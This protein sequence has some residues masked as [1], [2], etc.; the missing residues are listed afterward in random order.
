MS[1]RTAVLILLG[2]AGVACDTMIAD[3]MVIAT[4]SS[5]PGLPPSTA[6]LVAA[7]RAAA[8]KCGLQDNHVS[9]DADS[10]A[11]NDP[12]HLP[13]LH[14]VV[15]REGRNMFVTLAQDLYG[16]VGATDAYRCVRQALRRHLEQQFGR[17][18]VRIES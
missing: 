3:R 14:V 18:R 10:V 5:Q 7:T 15:R 4:P 9:S 16:P 1:R 6:E 17:E 11:W 12:A 8:E 2:F 13:G